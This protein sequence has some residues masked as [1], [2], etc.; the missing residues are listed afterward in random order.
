MSG[1]SPWTLTMRSQVEARGDLGQPVGA[2]EACVG[3]GQRGLAAER[4]HAVAIRSSSV[5]TITA[6]TAGRGARR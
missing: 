4:F 3:A 6:S 5:A 2:G 1:S